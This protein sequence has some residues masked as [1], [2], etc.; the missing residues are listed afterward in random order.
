MA[1]MNFTLKINEASKFNSGEFEGWGTSLCWWAN[2]VGYNKNLINQAV[3]KFYSPNGL[4]LNI[5]RYNIGGG[6]CVKDTFDT[7]YYIDGNNKKQVYDLTTS[8][9]KPE[10]FGSSMGVYSTSDLSNSTYT[11]TD[12]DLNISSGS[13]VGDIKAISYVSK[14]DDQ[15]DLGGPVTFKNINVT[16][17]GRYSL[18]LLLTLPG[19]N[20]RDLAVI[21]NGVSRYTK[22]KD[23]IN[24]N[25]IASGMI[26]IYI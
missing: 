19:T 18:K 2:R 23:I 17:T 20:D 11:R 4:N 3:D 15:V 26:E 8:G 6:D 21:V 25:V 13:T 12:N 22:G 24:N 7:P 10:Y 9:L 16:E 1:D 5:G 14:I